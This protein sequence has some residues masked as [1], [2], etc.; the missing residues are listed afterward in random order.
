MIAI[1]VFMVFGV[2]VII[3]YPFVRQRIRKDTILDDINNT[4]HELMSK[5]ESSYR[6]LREL[7]FDYRTNK[8][9]DEDYQSLYR[10]YKADA[11][12]TIRVLEEG[13]VSE[14]IL[15]EKEIEEEIGR[16]RAMISQKT[17]NTGVSPNLCSS[18]G[19]ENTSKGRFCAYCGAELGNPCKICGSLSLPDARFCNHCG[20]QLKYFCPQCGVDLQDGDKFCSSCG[21][22]VSVLEEN[23]R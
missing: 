1:M 18:C 2:L 21:T 7:D 14:T 17:T 13:A 6:A 22:S 10:T 16:R 8:L 5:K 12:A 23:E 20:A 9:S 4:E 11:L 19:K 3:G 15:L